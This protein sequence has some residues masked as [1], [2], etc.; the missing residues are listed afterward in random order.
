LVS[1]P[2]ILQIGGGVG[3]VTRASGCCMVDTGD[4]LAGAGQAKKVG[5][6][7]TGRSSRRGRR[8]VRVISDWLKILY[9]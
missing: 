5:R 3:G 8:R 1:G 4:R 9:L 7:R 2:G 6:G